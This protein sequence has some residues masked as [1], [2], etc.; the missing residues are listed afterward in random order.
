MDTGQLTLIYFDFT[1][2]YLVPHVVQSFLK[3]IEFQRLT[4]GFDPKERVYVSL[5]DFTDSA[6]AGA[7]VTPR[8]RLSIQIAP[9]SYQFETIAANDRMILIMNHELVHVATME[10]PA[11]ADQAYRQLF[12]GKVLADQGAARDRSSTST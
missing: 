5:F 11:G 7:S 1:E 8:N 2:S 3:S 6:D 9:L 10:Q 12:G 4:F